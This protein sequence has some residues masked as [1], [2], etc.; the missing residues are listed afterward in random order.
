MHYFNSYISSLL[1]GQK[2]NKS[3]QNPDGTHI[4][5]FFWSL[6]YC[7]RARDLIFVL[8]CFYRGGIPRV[9]FFIFFLV[10]P[11]AVSS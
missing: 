1:M 5:L 10:D 11:K 2:G 6:F 3:V 8:I 9:L 4:Q 7:E